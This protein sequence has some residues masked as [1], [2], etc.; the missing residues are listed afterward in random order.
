MTEP[1]SLPAGGCGWALGRTTSLDLADPNHRQHTERLRW[2]V[3]HFDPSVDAETL[4]QAVHSLARKWTH[5]PSVRSRSCSAVFADGYD[6]SRLSSDLVGDDG[7][8]SIERLKHDLDA[9]PD[10]KGQRGE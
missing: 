6:A 9:E 8:R 5:R 7:D 2:I 3:G 1:G 4:A 10:Q